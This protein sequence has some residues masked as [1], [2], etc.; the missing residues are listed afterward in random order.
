MLLVLANK[1]QVDAAA[2][3]AP[4]TG[5]SQQQ[6]PAMQG[7]GEATNSPLGKSLAK[8]LVQ[9]CSFEISWHRLRRRAFAGSL[10]KVWRHA[11]ASTARPLPYELF[12]R[13]V[14]HASKD[15]V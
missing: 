8:Y 11:R 12:D 9:E 14:E 4:S 13:S 15:L 2:I 3:A 7:I 1:N 10:K 5:S 6:A